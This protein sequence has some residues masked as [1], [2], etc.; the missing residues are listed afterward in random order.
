MLKAILL[1]IKAHAIATAAT[2]TTTVVVGTAAV[3]A[4]TI[5]ENYKLDKEVKENLHMLAS[6]SGVQQGVSDS[7]VEENT[8]VENNEVVENAQE[9]NVVTENTQ[10]VEN[11]QANDTKKNDDEPL[12][13]RIEKTIIPAKK[14]GNIV[15]NMKGEDA[16]EMSSE[17]TTSYK[18]V[19][20]YDKDYSKWTKEE[21]EEYARLL[22]EIAAMAEKEY[23][24]AVSR[25]EQAMR[26]AEEK[27]K[28]MEKDAESKQVGQ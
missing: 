12:T 18:I 23:K 9:T 27:A 17:E 20:S 16:Y 26:E 7:K 15:K 28:Q 8:Q 5:I 13:F 11:T 6:A 1:F 3:A 4:P 19:P 2:V 21:K 10:K 24:D 25:E 22:K 14:G